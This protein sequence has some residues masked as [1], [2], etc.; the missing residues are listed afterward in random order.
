[1]ASRIHRRRALIWLGCPLLSRRPKNVVP[2]WRADA[3]SDVIIFVM[4]AEMVLLQPEPDAS[5]HGKMVRRVMEH[6]VGNVTEDQS[7]KHARRQVPENQKEQTIEKKR[8]R[9]AYT[10]RHDEASS[11]VWIVVM[12]AVNNIVQSFSQTSFRLVMKYVTVDEVF[13]ERPEQNTKQ[14]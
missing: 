10:R 13:E 6:V 12:D 1:M 5:L 2:E 4:V 11:I 7:G 8:K 9:D 14:K 3:I